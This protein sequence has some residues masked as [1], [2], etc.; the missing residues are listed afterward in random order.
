MV[1]VLEGFTIG[2]GPS[3]SH[4]VGPMRAA[5]RFISELKVRE[6]LED[7]SALKVELFGSLAMTGEG[8][9]SDLAILMGLSGETPEGID[10]DS[11]PLKMAHIYKE[12]SLSLFSKVPVSFDPDLDLLFMKGKRLPYHSN[13][14]RFRAYNRKKKQILSQV[15]YSIGGGF[16]LN[17]AEAMRG[18]ETRSL[19]SVPFPFQNAAELLAYS[20]QE[21]KAIWEIIYEN[22]RIRFSE[23]VIEKGMKDIWA[24]MQS[25][26]ERGL[27]TRGVLP[28]GL[29]VI[30]RAPAL[31]QSLKMC[32]DK[33]GTDPTLVMEW[34]TLFALAV[35]EEN[36]SGSRIVTAPTNG[37]AGVIP[38]VM[39]YAQKFVSGFNEQSVFQFLLTATA[40]LKLFK[41]N[42]SIS[43]A[44]M[45]C[46]GEI[47]VASSMAAAGLAAILG[48]STEQIENAAE[49]AMEHHLG[50]T[51]DPVAGLVQIPCIERNSMGAIKAINAARM[52]MR[53]DGSHTVSLDAVI[54]AMKETGKNMKSIYRETSEGGLA[55]QVGLAE[56]VC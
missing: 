2:I 6:L 27:W 23:E 42:A 45:G 43:A 51:C 47:G 13:A 26:V 16:V 32:E 1:S 50:M 48:G 53:G 36:A 15:Y 30:R 8:H 44:E 17:H 9:G 37:A 24:A 21:N 33:I 41:L 46:Q 55:M 38:A 20:K 3:S 18:D 5:C 25:C 19:H 7:V 12:K 54:A 28:G 35:N 4:T 52:A 39:H 11:I 40:I 31:Y 22:E 29:N 56:T 14:I 10:P 34:V 49:I